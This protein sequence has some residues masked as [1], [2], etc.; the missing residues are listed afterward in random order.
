MA[1]ITLT[2]DQAI[3]FQDAV[4]NLDGTVDFQ[5]SGRGMY[6]DTCVGIVAR[7]TASILLHLLRNLPDEIADLFDG[8]EVRSD[9]MGLDEIVYFPAINT[10]YDPDDDDDDEYD[11]DDDD[12]EYNPDED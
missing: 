12:D 1:Y 2:D 11:P 10:E 7:D 4:D 8:V 3:E 9:S 6:G 5:Y